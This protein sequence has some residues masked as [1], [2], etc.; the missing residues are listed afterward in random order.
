MST[1][2]LEGV[3]LAYDIEGSGEPVLMIQGLVYGRRGWGPAPGM[4]ADRFRVATPDNRG[5]GESDAP[6][7]PYT[8]PQLAGDALAVLDAAEIDSAHVIG[9][10]LGG[11]IAQELVLAQPG[12]VRKL[13]LCS[14]TAGGPTAV[15]M[16][17]QTVALMGRAE[18]LDP[19]EAL[20]QFVVNA[21]SPD[22]PAELAAEIVAY[23]AANPPDPAGWWAQAAAGGAHD[24]MARLG[25]IRVPTLVV[26]G[27]ADNVVDVGNARLL[28]DAIEGARLELFEGVGHLLPWERP[29]EFTALV[30]GFL[31]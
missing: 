12:R 16:P 23:R 11:M 24:A 30:E 27:T 2:V 28:A 29:Q 3:R 17:E 19:Q 25:E 15:P 22:S 13:V 31:G 9:I 1:A 7:G 6:P 21:L 20:Q 26:H 18:H 8:T 4:L 5:F 10:S 14:T